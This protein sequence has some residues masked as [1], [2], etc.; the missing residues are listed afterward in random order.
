[1]K[2][3]KTLLIVTSLTFASASVSAQPLPSWGKYI[4][5]VDD[6]TVKVEASTSKP[7]AYEIAQSKLESL[8]NSSGKELHKELN[9]WDPDVS[10]NNIHLKGGSYI[11][12]QERMNNNAQVEYIGLVHVKVHYMERD[13]DN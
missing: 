5:S 7:R 8:E 10:S 13:T 4:D 11:T 3:L 2:H 12:V 1:M 9:M 6:K